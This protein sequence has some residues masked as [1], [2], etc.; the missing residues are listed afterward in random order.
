MILHPYATRTPVLVHRVHTKPLLSPY[1]GRFP[2]TLSRDY[3]QYQPIDA[4]SLNIKL[5]IYSRPSAL[6]LVDLFPVYTLND[7][8]EFITKI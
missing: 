8:N 4:N 1:T 7:K 3:R 5:P 2:L 6:L